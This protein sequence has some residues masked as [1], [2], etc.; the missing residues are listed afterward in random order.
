LRYDHRKEFAGL[1]EFPGF[2][3]KV[4]QL[5]GEA[6]IV[7]HAAELFHWPVEKSLFLGGQRRGGNRKQLGP[8]TVAAEQIRGPPPIPGFDRLTLR[9]RQAGKGMLCPPKDRPRKPVPTKREVTHWTPPAAIKQRRSL[10]V[11]RQ[12]T[13]SAPAMMR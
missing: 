6:P 5:P 12:T 9:F 2:R 7:D 1:Q 8:V 11:P 10:I 3:R 4:A 13:S